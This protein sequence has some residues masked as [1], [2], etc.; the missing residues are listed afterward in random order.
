MVVPVPNIPVSLRIVSTTANSAQIAWVEPPQPILAPGF[1]FFSDAA[2]RAWGLSST[3]SVTMNGRPVAGGSGTSQL[4]VNNQAIF[5]QDARTKMWWQFDPA[6]SAWSQPQAAD[7]VARNI[8]YQVRYRVLGSTKWTL[9]ATVVSVT[10][11]TVTGLL[12]NT[13]YEMEVVAS[14][15]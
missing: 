14:G 2:G 13:Q 6:K 9:F 8:T 15:H 12:P 7:P 3:G 11:L 5:G 10:S 1:T 4:T